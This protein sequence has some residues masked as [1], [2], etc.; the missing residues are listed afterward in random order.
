MNAAVDYMDAAGKI[1]RRQGEARKGGARRGTG[2]PSGTIEALQGD[3]GRAD[4]GE[5][6]WWPEPH[7]HPFRRLLSLPRMVRVM[8]DLVG[9]GFHYS[10]TRHIKYPPPRCC[11]FPKVLRGRRCSTAANGILMDNGAEGQQ[12][13]GGQRSNGFNGKRDAWTSCSGSKFQLPSV[14]PFAPDS[15]YILSSKINSLICGMFYWE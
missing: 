6:M 5:L 7:C 10:S 11:L 2:D 13:H 12:M 1:P 15:G 9:P 14:C 8:L 4:T 3:F